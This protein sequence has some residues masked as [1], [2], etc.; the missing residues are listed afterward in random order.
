MKT[1]F[2]GWAVGALLTVPLAAQASTL[3]ALSPSFKAYAEGPDFLAENL[4]GGLGAATGFLQAV[5][6]SVPGSWG[7][8]A[9][10]F[11]GFAT[12]GIALIERGAC[13]Y[14][15]KLANA[16][17]AGAIG[18]LIFNDGA[19]GRTETVA[20]DCEGCTLP[21]LFV[22]FAVGTELKAWLAQGPVRVA[23]SATAPEPVPEPGTLALLGLA[24][25][26][27]ALSRRRADGP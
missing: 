26:G 25:G 13:N 4:G 17:A 11:S 5:G 12:G 24:L 6:L 21:S 22:S 7:C 2:L 18:A 23:L 3:T 10:D 14:S 15:V 27:L 8:V 16:L 1:R 9:T 19:P 20:W